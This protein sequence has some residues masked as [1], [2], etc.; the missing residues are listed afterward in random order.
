[1]IAFKTSSDVLDLNFDLVLAD[2]DAGST[3]RLKVHIGAD[4]VILP[5][6]D[7]LFGESVEEAHADAYREALFYG[8]ANDFSSFDVGNDDITQLAPKYVSV[9]STFVEQAVDTELEAITPRLD[10]KVIEFV[11]DA[12]GG[13]AS[14]NIYGT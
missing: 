12:E 11:P 1:M 14:S 10:G 6:F 3:T 4:D 2:A 8:G 13:V 7:L 5:D 9:V